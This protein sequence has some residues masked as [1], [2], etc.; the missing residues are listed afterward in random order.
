[1]K[2]LISQVE[3]RTNNLIE[4]YEEVKDDDKCHDQLELVKDSFEVSDELIECIDKST[5][6]NNKFFDKLKCAIIRSIKEHLSIEEIKDKYGKQPKCLLD[7]LLDDLNKTNFEVNEV[8]EDLNDS[9]E[10]TEDI[11]EIDDN[12]QHNIFQFQMAITS[13]ISNKKI[14]ETRI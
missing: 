4:I 11:T 7:Y 13:N 3:K 10:S 9:E 1:M 12:L 6:Y 2:Y 8:S 5:K 14:T